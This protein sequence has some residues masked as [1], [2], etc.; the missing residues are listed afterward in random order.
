MGLI[1]A[2]AS[3]RRKELLEMLG[4]A[5]EIL[6]AKGEESITSS[7]PWKVV[8]ELSF[9]KAKEI[10]DQQNFECIV[11]GADTIVAKDTEIMGKPKDQA[12]AFRMLSKISEDS[13]EVYTGV[14]LIKTGAESQTVTFVEKTEVQIYPMSEKEIWDYIATGEPF[15]K[16]GAYA[17]QGKF[18]VY[19]KEIH[20]DYYNV[21]GLPIGRL[22]QE[23]KKI[24]LHS[25]ENVL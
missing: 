14:T 24:P 3:P 8:E 13:H 2:S 11:I 17:I 19:V 5:F 23:L 18:A 4:L 25:G 10:A 6:P 7:L 22:A 16:A 9:Q 21:V 12:D 15:D 20:G 1:L